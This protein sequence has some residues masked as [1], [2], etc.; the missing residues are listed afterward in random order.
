MFARITILLIIVKQFIK[1]LVAIVLAL[2][3]ITT[4][5]GKITKISQSIAEQKV[6]TYVLEKRKQT[7]AELRLNFGM[8]DQLATKKLEE[9]EPPIDDLA[10]FKAALTSLANRHSLSQ[11]AEF[12]APTEVSNVN[13]TISLAAN[14]VTLLGYLKDFEALPF[15]TAISA[16]DLRT[17]SGNWASD[18]TITIQAKL[19]TRPPID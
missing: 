6:T 11:T 7:I 3:V 10:E 9:A 4:F 17:T 1:A 2:I 15:L 16:I 12:A 13:Y 14:S 5:K 19:H 18:S 8:V